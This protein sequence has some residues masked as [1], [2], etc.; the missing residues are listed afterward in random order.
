MRVAILTTETLHHAYFVRQLAADGHEL[1]ALIEMHGVTPPYETAHPFEAAREEHE[2][3]HWFAGQ[4]GRVT[5][6]AD[7]RHF[8]DINSPEAVAALRGFVPDLAVCFGT[9]RLK[10]EMIAGGGDGLVNL[11]GGDPERYRGLD[12][13]LWAIWHR[14]FSA[15][16]TCLHRIDEQLDTGDIIQCLPVAPAPGSGLHQLRQANT[17]T[18]LRLVGGAID[19]LAVQGALKSRKQAGEGRYYSFMPAVLKEVCVKRFAHYMR[20]R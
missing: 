13:H 7:C 17:E 4:Q 3:T 10:G 2:R 9:R 1:L 18:C 12:T 16:Q 14:D 11:H 5:E 20:E 15:V 8:A 19:Q 6:F